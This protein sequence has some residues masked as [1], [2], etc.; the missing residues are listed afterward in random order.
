MA[1]VRCKDCGKEISTSANSCPNCGAKPIKKKTVL[2][3]A[4]SIPLFLIVAITI[5]SLLTPQY[6][7]DALE[8]R[9]VCEKIAPPHLQFE[10]DR[11]YQNDIAFGASVTDKCEALLDQKKRAIRASNKD[12]AAIYEKEYRECIQ[13]KK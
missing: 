11:I 5:Y 7:K 13:N 10:C 2:W 9:R 3:V 1:L 12:G 4:L 6:K 8:K